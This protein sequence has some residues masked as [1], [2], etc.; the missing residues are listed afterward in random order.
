LPANQ[1]FAAKQ[2]KIKSQFLLATSGH[3]D[4]S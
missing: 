3:R 1:N 4:K 2:A